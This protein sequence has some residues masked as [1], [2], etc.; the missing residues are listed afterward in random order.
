MPPLSGFIQKTLQAVFV[1]TLL[2]S[3]PPAA[4]FAAGPQINGAV[5]SAKIGNLPPQLFNV[6]VNNTTNL[7]Y[8]AGMNWLTM[9]GS[10]VVLDGKT[11]KLLNTVTAAN[12]NAELIVN[13]ANN[14]IWAFTNEADGV[15]GSVTVYNSRLNKVLDTYT[16]TGTDKKG[17]AYKV[18]INEAVYNP[19]SQKFYITNTNTY[20]VDVFDKHFNHL[21]ALSV[22]SADA[23]YLAVNPVTNTIYVTNYWA[24]AVTV[25]NGATDKAVGKPI[26]VGEAAW[27]YNCWNHTPF[28]CT[29]YNTS[30]SATDGIAVDSVTNKVYVANVH[31]GIMVTMDGNTNIITDALQLEP[32]LYGLLAAPGTDAIFGINWDRSTISIINEATG[33]RS[34]TIAV[35]TG[36]SKNCIDIQWTGGNCQS[37]GDF[38]S[39]MA[40]SADNSTLYV[41][42]SGNALETGATSATGD[43]HYYSTL[44]ILK[45][46]Q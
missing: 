25:I 32:G 24:T 17:K 13:E 41:I 44:Y 19:V 18:G 29:N 30:F 31:S 5:L 12:L 11:H 2:W 8:A 39:G 21:A 6:A 10:I 1:A 26:V 23:N 36:D 22:P 37:W 7:I 34:K 35:G 42:D 45:T 38:S 43:P 20:G 9:Q 14:T 27:P 40:I 33:M 28:N 15:T 46:T 16:L 4:V 3:L